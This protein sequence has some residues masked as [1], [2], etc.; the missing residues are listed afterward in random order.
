LS[1]SFT[2]M[3]LISAALVL[4]TPLPILAV[5]ILWITLIEDG[6]P[7][8]A[9]AYEPEEKGLMNEPPRKKTEPIL[10]KEVKV[11]IFIIALITDLLLLGLFL[12]LLRGRLD[13]PMIRTIIFA[14][15]AIDSLM[16]VFS[17]RSLRKNLWHGNPFSNKYLNVSVLIGFLTLFLGVYLPVLNKLLG[18]VPLAFSHWV[19]VVLFGIAN[20]LAIEAVKWVFI[21][22]DK[23]KRSG[24]MPD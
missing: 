8:L 14:G 10:N 19:L 17:C 21:V 11:L 9:L 3:L 20:V 2:E 23:R 15:L 4:G 24:A 22:R 12:F 1:D 5:Q 16:Y 13:L 6:L 18:T 7:G